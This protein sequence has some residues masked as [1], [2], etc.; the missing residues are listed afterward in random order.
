[1]SLFDMAAEIIAQDIRT[2]HQNELLCALGLYI[3]FG[4]EDSVSTEISAEE[5]KAERQKLGALVRLEQM[6]SDKFFV[7]SLRLGLARCFKKQN[8]EPETLFLKRLYEIFPRAVADGLWEHAY[9]A[10]LNNARL[11]VV[12]SYAQIQELQQYRHDMLNLA[13]THNAAR[14]NEKASPRLNGTATYILRC[15]NPVCRAI[16]RCDAKTKN[17]ACKS[18]K[19]PDVRNRQHI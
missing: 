8:K 14:N 9:K 12:P 17:F 15:S 18:C 7:L 3:E 19:N 2:K 5:F 1:M 11:S 13:L 4:F 6:L 10:L 16:K